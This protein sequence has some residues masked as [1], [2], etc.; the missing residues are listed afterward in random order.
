MKHLRDYQQELSIKAARIMKSSSIVYLAMEVR[1]GKTATAMN[2]AKIQK[3]KKVLFLTKKKAIGSIESD[4]YDFGFKRD[5]DI[6]VINNESLHNVSDTDFDF[7]IMDE[8]HR[9]GSFPKPSKGAKDFKARFSHLPIVFLSGT[10]TPE[11]YSQ[12]FNQLWVSDYSPFNKYK[13]FYQ[14]AKDF[15]S[16]KVKY[17]SYGTCNDYSEANKPMIDDYT[18]HLFVTF[19]QKEAGFDTSVNE[20]ILMCDI[21][22]SVIDL[23]NRLSKDLVIEGAKETILAE[24]SVKLMQKLHQMYSGTVKFESGNSA[25]LDT[26]KAEFIRNRFIGQK[27]GIFYKFKAELTAIKTIFGDTITEDIEEFNKTNKNIA[28]QIVSGREGISLKEA[29]YLVYYNIDFS[30]TSYWQSRDRLTTMERKTNDVYFVFARGGIEEKI[31]KAVL[32]KKNYTLSV[33][34]KDYGFQAPNKNYQRIRV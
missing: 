28:L 32:G 3:A 21:K 25:V 12:I 11:S 34:K 24:T 6:S 18:K 2:V 23:C 22:P 4:Y 8:A 5:F 16:V 13:N 7:I 30:A 29:Q 1:T 31:Y 10:P 14:W 17:V 9:F 26:S 20:N 33:F 27:I 15:V 19:T